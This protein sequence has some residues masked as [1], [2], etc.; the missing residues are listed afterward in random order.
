MEGES[1]HSSAGRMGLL[2]NGHEAKGLAQLLHNPRACRAVAK[3]LTCDAV[4]AP[5]RPTIM[6]TELTSA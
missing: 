5:I 1:T 6:K 4:G 2:Q 3:S